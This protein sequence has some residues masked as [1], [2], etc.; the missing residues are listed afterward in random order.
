MFT[1]AANKKSGNANRSASM[2]RRS[3]VAGTLAAATLP[4]SARGA[5]AQGGY[6]AKPIR[7]I[8]GFGPGGPADSLSRIMADPLSRYL[9]QPV[10]VEARP[11]AGG[12]IGAD[13]VAK[14]D[15]DGYTIGLVTG[16]HAVSAALYNRLPFDSV[17]SFQMISTI[18][19]Y[20][21]VVA[22][23]PDFEAST[24][25]Q[26]IALA[27]AK[28]RTLN[29]GSGGVGTTQ[30]LAG[31]LLRAMAGIET[32]HVP[33]RGDAA[34]VLGLLG[35]Q[36]HFIVA[37]T[38]A[39]MPQIAA[40]A[41]RPLAVTTGERWSGLPD[42]PTVTENGVAG[43][44]VR[45]WAGLLAPKGLPDPVLAALFQATASSVA[46]P[47]VK[48]KLE[49]MVAGTARIRKP[50]EMAGMVASE[51]ARWRKVVADAGIPKQ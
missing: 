6:P 41:L 22:A 19:E 2:D 8:H 42:V 25:R 21:F 32:T 9:K 46:E 10:I 33:Y 26:L 49:G 36:V 30:H 13:A 45:T 20:A 11:G 14:A 43:F 35:K 12:N 29:F 38:S 48:A 51:I 7:L 27:K 37:A 47:D 50:A 4:L 39:V 3:F 31:E 15:P 16:G 28:P 17:E 40:G 18:V 1:R 44:D 24:L 23:A 34:A 5:S